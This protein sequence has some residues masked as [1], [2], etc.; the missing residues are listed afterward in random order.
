VF[1]HS[2]TGVL[3]RLDSTRLTRFVN[4]HFFV[5]YPVFLKALFQELSPILGF[6]LWNT[7]GAGLFC[8][9]NPFVKTPR[10]GQLSLTFLLLLDSMFGPPSLR[11]LNCP[12]VFT[13][14]IAST[15]VPPH[16]PRGVPRSNNTSPSFF[17]P[18]LGL[19]FLRLFTPVVSSFP[20][21]SFHLF[22]REDRLRPLK[23]RFLMA[24]RVPPFFPTSASLSFLGFF[25]GCEVSRA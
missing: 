9:N 16:K 22:P 3:Q 25:P 17:P 14:P 24:F 12:V 18:F 8:C 13:P 5:R 21:L 10:G 20:L 19:I 4:G 7:P 11:L 1:P 15:C 6:K 23:R 2:S